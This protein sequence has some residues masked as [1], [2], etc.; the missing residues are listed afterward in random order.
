MTRALSRISSP[1][2][3]VNVCEFEGPTGAVPL[4][5]V[6]VCIRQTAPLLTVCG[7]W[8]CELTGAQLPESPIHGRSVAPQL[9]GSPGNPR[10]WIHIQNGDYL[11]DHNDQLRRVV[12]LGEERAQPD[13][14]EYPRKEAAARRALQAAF[15][16]LGP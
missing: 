6:D 13:A 1:G 7:V 9:L 8:L 16:A 3:I 12:P 11:L 4:N 15:E 2:E 14:Q 5:S 10:E